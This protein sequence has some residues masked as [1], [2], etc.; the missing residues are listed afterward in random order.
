MSSSP[1]PIRRAG[2]DDRLSANAKD[3]LVATPSGNLYGKSPGGSRIVYSR[4]QLLSLAS[5]PLSQTPPHIPHEISRSPEK[6]DGLV[7]IANG[8]TNGVVGA[9]KAAP[10]NQSGI[11]LGKSP[12][13]GYA[14]ASEIFKSGSNGT[15]NGNAN[16]S[17]T[18]GVTRTA[19]VPRSPPSMA[20]IARSPGNAF[21]FSN[22][23][24]SPNG[25]SHST[26]FKE[27]MAA[28]QQQ[29]EQRGGRSARQVS[30]SEMPS[31][32]NG[33]SEGANGN[34]ADEQFNMEM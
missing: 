9:G 15:Q 29:Q 23:P 3:M 30:D 31:S 6:T 18:N 27:R 25:M 1:L 8:R 19:A 12:S 4:E 11:G 10:M 32:S 22:G 5:S 2:P 33:V 24:V 17:G 26:S 28:A 14:A 7:Q 21:N 13:G 34:H 16:G 20:G